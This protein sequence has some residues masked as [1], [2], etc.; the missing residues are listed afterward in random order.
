MTLTE[1]AALAERDASYL[2][3]EVAHSRVM[4]QKSGAGTGDV[5]VNV[6]EIRPP[7]MDESGRTKYPVLFQ[8]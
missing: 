3:A 6:M 1:N 8:V 7:L 5:N 2:H 4:L